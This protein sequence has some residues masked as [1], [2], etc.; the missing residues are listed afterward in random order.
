MDK[1]SV[2][3]AAYPKAYIRTYFVLKGAETQVA[4]IVSNERKYAYDG[5]IDI[6]AKRKYA[7][8]GSIDIYTKRYTEFNVTEEEAW[9]DAA[10]AVEMEMI[11]RLC[12]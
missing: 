7:Y 12:N 10:K 8:G 3:L 9:D 4:Y 2:V 5:S 11:N 1:R 6:Y